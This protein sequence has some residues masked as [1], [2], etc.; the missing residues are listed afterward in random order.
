MVVVL[1]ATG[2]GITRSCLTQSMSYVPGN[3][4][5]G[6]RVFVSMNSI[7]FLSEAIHHEG[8]KRP[9]QECVAG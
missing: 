8:C 4:G 6:G 5:H 9:G 3:M 7:F 2:K 1:G